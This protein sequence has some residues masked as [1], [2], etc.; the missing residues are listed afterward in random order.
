MV[1]GKSSS[2]PECIGTERR[3]TVG[4]LA[5]LVAVD[6]GLL[7]LGERLA[8][9]AEHAADGVGVAR[10]VKV[11]LDGVASTYGEHE[12]ARDERPAASADSQ[13]IHATD[14]VEGGCGVH[15]SYLSRWC[16][17][18]KREIRA[19]GGLKILV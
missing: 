13:Q 9:S 15:A 5:H 4:N 18:V 14:L 16:S 2:V 1:G 3:R 7:A 17:R 10:N 8:A 12:R 11:N 6:V 19:L